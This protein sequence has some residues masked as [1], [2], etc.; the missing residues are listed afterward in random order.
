MFCNNCGKEFKDDA[1]FCS[2]CGAQSAA[3]VQPEPIQQ[4]SVRQDTIQQEAQTAENPSPGG[5]DYVP[6]KKSSGG[7]ILF[8][9]VAVL[10]AV[11]LIAAGA[12]TS[13]FGLF[14]SNAKNTKA[15]KAKN[16]VALAYEGINGISLLNSFGFDLDMTDSF[17]SKSNFEGYIKHGKT[18]E[19]T[20][21]YVKL[22]I[23]GEKREAALYNGNIYF[24]EDKDEFYFFSLS[25][26]FENARESL[27]DEIDWIE[28]S[29]YYSAEQKRAMIKMYETYKE[30]LS[31][32]YI[33]KYLGSGKIDREKLVDSLYSDILTPDLFSTMGE[34]VPSEYFTSGAIRQ[35]SEL[36][37]AFI[38]EGLSDESVS[39]DVVP[40]IEKSKERGITTYNCEIDFYE[41]VKESLTYLADNYDK[42][43]ELKSSAEGLIKDSQYSDE[44]SAELD[45]P[46]LSVETVITAL[47]D[48]ALGE[49]SDIDLDNAEFTVAVDNKGFLR[50]LGFEYDIIDFSL[51]I[52]DPNEVKPDLKKLQSIA[53]DA[54]EYEF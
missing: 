15:L 35:L 42:Y 34:D 31:I 32:D 39:D 5:F 16:P 18:V 24:E 28:D 45:L 36:A 52:T 20:V 11:A 38:H 27:D 8:S 43:K 4:E 51:E 41:A 25:K 3:N 6:R 1:K 30:M 7:K 2:N 54:E 13:G 48:M 53:K 49:L 26:L 21:F 14:V 17:A 29:Y 33:N 47:R 50:E 37:E 46:N 19:D 12:V 9:L 40:S 22:T 44:I 10:A 23:D